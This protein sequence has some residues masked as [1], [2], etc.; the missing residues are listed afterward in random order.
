MGTVHLLEAVRH[1]DGVRAVVCITS[2]KCYENREWLWGYREYEAMGGLDPYS[3][4]KGCAELVTKAYRNS[5]L[6]DDGNPGGSVGVAT[7]RAGNVIGGGDWATDR[8]VPDIL[9]S[10]AKG[11]RVVIRNP[12][13]IR[14]W[15][16]VLDPLNGYL[17][18]AEHLYRN[19]RDYSESWNFGPP[20]SNAR[21]VEWLVEYL[22]SLC[23]AP[24]SWQQD[25]RSQP[26]EDIQLTLDSS[27]ARLRLDWRAHLELRTALEWVVEWIRAFQGGSDMRDVSEA[28]IR[29]FMNVVQAR[30][31]VTE[32]GFAGAYPFE[33]LVSLEQQAQ[34]LELTPDPTMVRSVDGTIVYWNHRAAR[35]YGWTKE[36][37]IGQ[38]SHSLLQTEFPASLDEMERQLRSNGYW[39]GALVHTTREGRRLEVSSYWAM[40]PQNRLSKTVVLEVNRVGARSR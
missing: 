35:V 33:T 21:S 17:T 29:R 39:E 30:E 34:L 5:F 26:H 8:L 4:S 27:K 23:G 12:R 31:A 37:A 11:K 13:A 15:Q 22:L 3:S 2:D 18:L 25:E 10:L 6:K 7:G 14:P 20:E 40:Q 28:Q 19:G 38:I 16:H 24:G 9:R 1:V 32:V 36:E